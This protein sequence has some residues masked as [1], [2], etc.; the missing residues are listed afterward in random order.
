MPFNR[1]NPYAAYQKTGITTASQGKLV[2]MLYQGAVRELNAAVECF[3]TDP[4]TRADTIKPQLIEQFG[5][6]VVRAQEIIGELQASLDMEKGV[7]IAQNLMSLYVY[8]NQELSDA[9]VHKDRKKI[10]FVLDM[11]KQ[12]LSAWE[13]AASTTVATNE[14][15]SAV[16]IQ[17]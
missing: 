11:M 16:N 4:T 1:G 2:V 12:L 14:A 15:H 17:G 8:F 7:D 10:T 5:K 9:V 13:T 6:H 3:S